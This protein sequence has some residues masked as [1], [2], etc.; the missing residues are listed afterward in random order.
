MKQNKILI[1]GGTGF[2]GYHLAKKCL[3]LKW[4]VHSVSTRL[5]KINRRL[6]K[7]KYL[8]FDISNKKEIKNKLSL[9]YNYVVNLAGYV[10]HS[11]K[12]KVLKSHFY[13]CKNL[14]EFFLNSNIKKFVQIGSCIEYGKKSS[15]Q[16]ENQKKFFLKNNSYYGTAKLLS[17][18]FLLDLN[19]RFNF[20]STILRLYLVYGPNQALNRIIPI[21][22]SNAIK[23]NKFDCSTGHQLRDFIYVDDVVSAIIKILKNNNTSGE[24]INVGSG[25]P[26]S[27]K[28]TINKICKLVGGGIPVF[29]KI[30]LREDE[31]IKLY[32]N[33]SKAKNLLK[34]Q[35]KVSFNYGIKKTIKYFKKFK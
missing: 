12:K 30:S 13:G 22:I 19:K 2:I 16:R 1:T 8:T 9:E 24:I 7:V 20:P 6:K 29:G 23:D 11:H 17:T 25:K 28:K 26:I 14:A 31:M 3:S 4:S 21:T 35:P 5:P 10:D 18:K 27:I 15:P 32:P 34:W 33:I